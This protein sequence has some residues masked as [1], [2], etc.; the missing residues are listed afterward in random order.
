MPELQRFMTSNTERRFLLISAYLR[1][2]RQ[3]IFIR[4]AETKIP[5]KRQSNF[6]R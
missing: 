2:L 1:N 3:K 4:A 5:G 6:R